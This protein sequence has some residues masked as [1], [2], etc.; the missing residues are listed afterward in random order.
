MH[1]TRCICVTTISASSCRHWMTPRTTHCRPASKSTAS[2]KLDRPTPQYVLHVGSQPMT[3]QILAILPTVPWLWIA[4]AI[5]ALMV[6]AFLTNPREAPWGSL[7]LFCLSVAVLWWVVPMMW[8]S[9]VGGTPMAK[10]LNNQAHS[11]S[12]GLR[13]KSRE[14]KHE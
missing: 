4:G 8:A 6:I 13:K 2:R 11:L 1:P 14:L 5:I 3:A 12:D 10:T 7:V 9:F